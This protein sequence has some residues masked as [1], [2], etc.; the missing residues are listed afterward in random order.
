M[1]ALRP[2]SR[3]L[4][5]ILEIAQRQN[6]S[7]IAQSGPIDLHD[8]P[9]T[10]SRCAQIVARPHEAG[11]LASEAHSTPAAPAASPVPSHA[12]DGDEPV[13]ASPLHSPLQAPPVATIDDAAAAMSVAPTRGIAIEP[14]QA[15]TVQFLIEELQHPLR[16][17]A[18]RL[19]CC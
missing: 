16:T 17:S 8:Q 11:K 15:Q 7:K 4:L 2:R 13:Q 3:R 14:Q 18:K 5:S 9:R 12:S 6:R 19:E 1:R 10:R